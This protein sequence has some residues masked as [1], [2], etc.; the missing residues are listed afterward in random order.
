M[1]DLQIIADRVEIEALR[2]EFTDAALMRD[3]DRFASLFTPDSAWRMPYVNVEFLSREEIRAGIERMQGLWDH[4]LQTAH[5]GTIELAGDTAAGRA[6]VTEFGRFR[7]G[8]S[9]LHLS[10]YHDRYQRT[11]DGWKFS[12]RA[13]QIKYLDTAP[14]TGSPPDP[15]PGPTH[16]SSPAR[17]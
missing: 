8:S 3:W 7:D 1:S 16:E 11:S 5:P 4:F 15:A 13:Y 12:E 14:L 2:A 10:V 9:Q 17:S 6:Y